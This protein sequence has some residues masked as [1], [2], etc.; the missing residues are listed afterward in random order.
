MYKKISFALV[1]MISLFSVSCNRDGDIPFEDQEEYN[2]SMDYAVVE[3]LPAPGQF[4]NESV[5]GF[6][7]ITSSAEAIAF[8]EKRLSQNLYVS[9]GAWGGYIVVKFKKSIPNKSGYD[10]AIS[11]NNFDS[12]NEPGIVWV[13]KDSNGN[14]LP[15]D[16]WYELKGSYYGQPGYER[17]F[18]VKYF[19]PDA[20]GDTPWSDSN[21]ETGVVK[22]MGSQHNQDFYYPEWIK[23]DSY[24]LKGSKLPLR[25]QQ[26]PVSG[27]WENLPFDWGYVD[28]CGSDSETIE[29]NGKKLDINRFRISDAIDGAG[30]AVS[31]ESID[32]IKVQTAIMG[33]AGILGE[34]STEVCGFFAF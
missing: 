26:N 15:D 17:N 5:T 27:M 25:A 22:W 1:A 34:N 29:I 7:N 10:F 18:W 28:N 2:P 31:L 30:N 21:G 12:S 20:K 8:A 24:T 3:Y 32:F 33:S 14:G 9:L 6:D 19:R 11:G 23:D 4:I 16:T 13:M